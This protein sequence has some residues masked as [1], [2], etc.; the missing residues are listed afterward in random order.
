MTHMI[1]DN[2][3]WNRI[4]G[5]FK[6]NR[7]KLSQFGKWKRVLTKLQLSELCASV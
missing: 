7:M 5:N 3:K 2:V 4:T 1:T 6:W